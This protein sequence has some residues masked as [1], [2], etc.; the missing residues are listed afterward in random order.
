MMLVTE[1]YRT[2]AGWRTLRRYYWFAGDRTAIPW[3]REAKS[4]CPGCGRG[5]TALAQSD[6]IC[7]GGTPA[8]PRLPNPRRPGVSRGGRP[9]KSP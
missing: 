8:W 6:H 4:P 3:T 5:F 1:L 2:E 9:K 7:L